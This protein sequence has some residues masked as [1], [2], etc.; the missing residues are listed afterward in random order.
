VRLLI[1]VGCANDSVLANEIHRL[2]VG[3]DHP[4]PGT[5]ALLVPAVMV[6]VRSIA[7]RLL[8]IACLGLLAVGTYACAAKRKLTA[9]ET[10]STAN[11]AFDAG[12]Y[13]IAVEQYKILLD[14]HPFDENA[15]EA[16]TKIALSYYLMDRYAEAIAAFS[17]FERMHP[18]SP[19]VPL[20]TYYLGMSYLKQMRPIDRDQSASGSA[21]AY[22][23][24]VIDRYP[25]SP[26]A[27]RAELRRRECEEA[28][29]LHELYV[30]SFYLRQKNLTAAE[31]RL[32]NLMESYSHTDAEA[33]AL[34]VFGEAYQKRKLDEPA[35]LAFRTLVQYHPDDPLTD[36]ATRALKRLDDTAVIPS[37]SDPRTL[38]LTHL[39]LEVFGGEAP[40]RDPG[41]LPALEFNELPDVGPTY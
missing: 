6:G 35:T 41:A 36:G 30:A 5:R 24:A 13:E 7:R 17:D 34:S 10:Y 18:T 27:A 20:V 8:L 11:E 19:N 40:P 3:R 22:F 12:A 37:D 23:Q 9:Q 4:P 21:H 15:V 1:S 25:D 38:L 33:R 29:A 16:E 28:L 14:E 26:W 39:R 31:A 2:D 32:L